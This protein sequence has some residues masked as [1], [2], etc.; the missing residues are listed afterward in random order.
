MESKIW[1][2]SVPLEGTREKG[3]SHIYRN[4]SN[5]NELAS[6]PVPGILSLKQLYLDLFLNKHSHKN[7]LGIH[8]LT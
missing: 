1:D 4:S 7:F 8:P 2:F 6:T 3:F 5:L